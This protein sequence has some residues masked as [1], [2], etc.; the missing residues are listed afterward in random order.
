MSVKEFGNDLPSMWAD[1]SP[2]EVMAEVTSTFIKR[3]AKTNLG[4][5]LQ[6]TSPLGDEAN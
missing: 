4:S 6:S 5:L 2:L 1:C 3:A